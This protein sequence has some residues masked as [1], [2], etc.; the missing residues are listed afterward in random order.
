MDAVVGDEMALQGFLDTDQGKGCCMERVLPYDK[1]TLGDGIGA[2]FRKSDTALREKFNKGI[3][4]IRADGT[5]EKIS[6]K[7]FSFNIYGE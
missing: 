4:D 1:E 2:G 3:A 7:Y 6:K 5:Y